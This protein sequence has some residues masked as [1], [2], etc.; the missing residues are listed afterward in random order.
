MRGRFLGLALVMGMKLAASMHCAAEGRD[1]EQQFAEL[2][3]CKLDS[4]KQISDC[5]LG[6]RTWGTLNAEKTNAILVPTWFTGTSQ[7]VEQLVGSDKMLDPTRFF[8]IAVDSLGDGVSSSPSTGKQQG[9]LNFPE[10]T[11]HDMVRAEYRLATE[12]IPLKHLHAVV[13]VSM[14]GIQTFEWMVDYPDFMELAVPIVGTPRPTSYDLLLWQAEEDGVRSDPAWQGG[15]YTKTPALFQVA[16][17][18]DMNTT[19][20]SHYAHEVSRDGFAARYAEYRSK[21]VSDFDANDRIYQLLALVHLDVAHGATLEEAAKK[22]H[23]KTLIVTS[24]QDHMVNPEPAQ[25]F[26]KM[27]GAKTIALTSD[28]GHLALLCEADKLNPEVRAFLNGK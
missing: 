7:Q 16:I 25:E 5:R 22:V 15:N 23:A 21:G 8:I 4:G 27:L 24:Q 17:L 28:C 20:P 18:H 14:G 9:R 2:G 1:G 3:I 26:A 13:G 12:A 10:F 19:T 6:Y 11:V